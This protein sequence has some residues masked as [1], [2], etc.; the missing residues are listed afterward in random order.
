MS[1]LENKKPPKNGLKDPPSKLTCYLVQTYISMYMHICVYMYMY[2]FCIVCFF[3]EHGS[4]IIKPCTRTDIAIR[5][6]GPDFVSCQR[7]PSNILCRL[8]ITNSMIGTNRNCTDI[9]CHIDCLY[10]LWLWEQMS[11]TRLYIHLRCQDQQVRSFQ[12]T[13]RQSDGF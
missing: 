8:L 12:T 3:N 10:W 9:E 7:T 4:A 5:T 2:A 13:T 6:P 11:H 1:T